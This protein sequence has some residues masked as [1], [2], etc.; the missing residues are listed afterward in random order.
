MV[1]RN[2][3]V[4]S[5]PESLPTFLANNHETAQANIPMNSLVT[6]QILTLSGTE[7]LSLASFYQIQ[8]PQTVVHF[9]FKP[10]ASALPVQYVTL[11]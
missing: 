1:E 4:F 10:G 11:T 5:T 7:G 6:I 8:T 9:L 3:E 2:V